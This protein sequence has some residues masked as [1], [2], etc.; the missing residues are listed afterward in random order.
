MILTL[1]KLVDETAFYIQLVSLTGCLVLVLNIWAFV[2]YY[3]NAGS[4]YRNIKDEQKAIWVGRV[5]VF[6]T[7]CILIKLVVLWYDPELFDIEKQ[8]TSDDLGESC[9]L[10]SI[11]TLT[12]MFPTATVL[13]GKF[14]ATF[15]LAHLDRTQERMSESIDEG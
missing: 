5:A 4:P 6:W 12:E 11:I 9:L 2:Q 8:F 13:E 1:F 10:F 3:S 7:V 15:T 14:I